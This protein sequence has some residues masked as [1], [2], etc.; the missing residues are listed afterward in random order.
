MHL[1]YGSICVTHGEERLRTKMSL[2][3]QLFKNYLIMHNNLLRRRID[4]QLYILSRVS[5]YT[6]D[7]DW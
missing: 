6:R 5:D 2:I 4:N 3:T 1:N 7:L